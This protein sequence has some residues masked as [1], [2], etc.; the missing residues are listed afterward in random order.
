MYSKEALIQK[1]RD[2]L[3]VNDATPTIT[4]GAGRL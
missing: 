2:Y 4:L 3:P 1:Y